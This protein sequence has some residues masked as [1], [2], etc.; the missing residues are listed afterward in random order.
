[1]SGF[2]MQGV[3]CNTSCSGPCMSC[4]LPMRTGTCSPLDNCPAQDAGLD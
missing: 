1:V 3:C 2:C 4:N